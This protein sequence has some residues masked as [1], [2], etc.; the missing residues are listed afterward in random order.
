MWGDT[1]EWLLLW[2]WEGWRGMGLR[3]GFGWRCPCTEHGTGAEMPLTQS[4]SPP[5]SLL[6]IPA[7][8]LTHTSSSAASEVLSGEGKLRQKGK[9]VPL[10]LLWR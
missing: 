6:C 10:G 8:P 7:Q 3:G 1:S 5:P 4:C 2:G 9:S